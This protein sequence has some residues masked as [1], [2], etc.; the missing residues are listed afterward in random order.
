MV[1]P[2]L[3]FKDVIAGWLSCSPSNRLIPLEPS[4]VAIP[5]NISIPVLGVSRLGERLRLFELVLLEVGVEIL[6]DS[7]R[8]DETILLI[9]LFNSSSCLI[10]YD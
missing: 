8:I 9:S 2:P 7:G 6:S 10:I 4:A 5:A 1:E 3:I